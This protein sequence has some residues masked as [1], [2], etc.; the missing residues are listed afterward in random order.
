LRGGERLEARGGE[1]SVL[2][3]QRHDVG[4][5]RKRDEVEPAPHGLALAAEQRLRELVHDARAAQLGERVARRPRGDDRTVGERVTRAMVVGHDHV[6]AT[7]A[8]GG[9]LL[10]RRDPAVDGQD[11]PAALVRE[12]VDRVARDAVPLLEPA[13]EVPL[14]LG[15]EL[16]QRQHCKRRGA[17]AVRVVVAVYADALAPLDGGADALARGPHVAQ[18]ERVVSGVARLEERA[19]GVGLREPAAGEHRRG[20]LADAELTGE[21]VGSL[22]RARLEGPGA[23]GHSRPTVRPWSDGRTPAL[24]GAARVSEPKGA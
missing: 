16:A 10:D 9:H 4:D 13:R 7:G 11:E 8:R 12:P 6:E 23:D 15:A 3:Q 2:V 14:H 24:A 21:R 22:P 20:Q 1:R 18:Q 5:G 19:G 17:D